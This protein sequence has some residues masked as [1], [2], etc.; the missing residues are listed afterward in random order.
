M[1]TC[2]T[3]FRIFGVKI[4]SSLNFRCSRPFVYLLPIKCYLTLYVPCIVTNYTNKPTRCTFCM[5]LFYNLYTTPHVSNDHFVLHQ[6]FMVYSMC[7]SVQTLHTCLDM[8]VQSC[9][10]SKSLTP[11]DER[12]GLQKHV[13][14]YKKLQNKYIQKVHLVGLFVQL[15]TMHGTYNVKK[16]GKLTFRVQNPKSV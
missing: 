8:F 10:Q 13:E 1:Q 7:S 5:Y 9:G 14:L 2:L 16:S 4:F 3:Y 6:E 12:N 15:V 11:D